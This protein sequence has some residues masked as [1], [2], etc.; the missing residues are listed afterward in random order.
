MQTESQ[1]DDIAASVP[2][3]I[4]RLA[5]HLWR[6]SFPILLGSLCVIAVGSCSIWEGPVWD[7]SF[8]T[9]LVTVAIGGAAVAVVLALLSLAIATVLYPTV[10]SMQVVEQLFATAEESV[11]HAEY[12]AEPDNPCWRSAVAALT[13]VLAHDRSNMRAA[14]GLAW[15]IGHAESQLT[16]LRT[17][18]PND[19]RVAEWES[20]LSGVQIRGFLWIED[21]PTR[22]IRLGT[23]G[24]VR[25][26]ARH[27]LF[28]GEFARASTVPLVFVAIAAVLILLRGT[29][30]GVPVSAA[31]FG[32]ICEKAV[33]WCDV[34]IRGYDSADAYQELKRVLMTTYPRSDDGRVSSRTPDSPTCWELNTTG[35]KTISKETVHFGDGETRAFSVMFDVVYGY[36]H[37]QDAV[38]EEFTVS[39]W[40]LIPPLG[41][42]RWTI[43]SVSEYLTPPGHTCQP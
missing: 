42:E 36:G 41:S 30:A 12:K 19:P 39:E 37:G 31:F 10:R 22:P 15:L 11:T 32:R 21:R 4:P 8:V 16:Q 6:I 24:R 27:V 43:Q 40:I 25:H 9:Y 17:A 1:P 35:H 14:R 20:S 5:K 33:P 26:F 38:T 7:L 34:E 28:T 3:D 29:E 13:D 23:L 2:S 18:N